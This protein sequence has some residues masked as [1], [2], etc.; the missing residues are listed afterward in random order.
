VAGNTDLSE[1]ELV[2]YVVR[3]T[4]AGGFKARAPQALV[5]L[6]Q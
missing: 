2:D 4:R 6:K 1:E 3:I 5:V